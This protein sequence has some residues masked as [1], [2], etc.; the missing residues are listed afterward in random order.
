MKKTIALL[1]LC[2]M[3]LSTTT[4]LTAC[5][6]EKEKQEAADGTTAADTSKEQDNLK[7]IPL[8]DVFDRIKSSDTEYP[9]LVSAELA[10][11]RF[12]YYF[13][14][15]Q[16]ET[17]AEALAME[18]IIGSIPFFVGFLR[19]NSPSGALEL[20]KK[21]ESSVDP[22]KWVCV[23]ASYVKTAVNGSVILL[24]MDNDDQRGEALIRAFEGL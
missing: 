11:D 12:A 7:D 16:P 22:R 6:G 17:M 10:A 3:T 20:A 9:N 18:P 21:I 2:A 13:G 15:E 8:Q 19:L 23:E 5:K 1:L 14:I 4:L 24:V